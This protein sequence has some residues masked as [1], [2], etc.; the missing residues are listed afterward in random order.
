MGLRYTFTATDAFICVV[1]EYKHV[2]MHR[3][4]LLGLVRM[5]QS[6]NVTLLQNNT[7]TV[8]TLHCTMTVLNM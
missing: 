1:T 5:L 7:I 8:V 2:C 4:A 3:Q 6:S